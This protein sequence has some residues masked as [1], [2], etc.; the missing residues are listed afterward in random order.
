MA[1]SHDSPDFIQSLIKLFYMVGGVLVVGRRLWVVVVFWVATRRS[2]MPPSA[3]LALQYLLFTMSAQV[4]LG[5]TTLLLVVPLEYAVA[6]QGCGVL[7]LICAVWLLRELTP[8]S[9]Q[10]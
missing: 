3:T 9:K 1:D 10:V 2:D 7:L 5:I 8:P 4:A 6:H